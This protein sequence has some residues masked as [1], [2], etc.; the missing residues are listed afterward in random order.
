MTT[1]AVAAPTVRRPTP[2][3][4]AHRFDSPIGH[5][6]LVVERSCVFDVDAGTAALL[7]GLD[8]DPSATRAVLDT[9]AP[10]A[11]ADLA[12]PVDPPWRSMSLNVSQACNLGCEYCYADGGSFGGTPRMMSEEV[13]R[14]AVARLIDGCEPGETAR[15]AFMGGEPLLARRVMRATIEDAAGRARAAGVDVRFAVTTNGTLL[16]PD[17]VEFFATHPVTLTISIDGGAAIHDSL[18]R[19]KAGDGSWHRI[20]ERL[21]PV[22]SGDAPRPDLVARV[23][24]TRRHLDLPAILADLTEVGFTSIGC[25][26]MLTGPGDLALRAEDL[27]RYLAQLSVVAEEFVA[28]AL[29]GRRHPFATLATAL[30]EVHRG[31]HRPYPCGAGAGYLNVSADGRLYAC[32]RFSE[33]PV[34][35]L[36]D[37][38]G[39]VDREGQRTWLETRHVD[40]QSPCQSCWARYLCGGGCHHEV[41]TAGRVACDFVRSWLDVVLAAYVRIDAGNPAWFGGPPR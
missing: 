33:D 8:G 29:A 34:G 27:D 20:V 40:R 23:T 5:H 24:I 38:D 6:L 37:L 17:D 36:G 28:D 41:L 30:H 22:L 1:V 11:P 32:H 14:E 9:I 15:I 18:R 31:T 13:A 10:V 35:R 21:R 2:P 19:T 7:D 12:A 39:G 4:V 26:P 25:S 3:P 16:R